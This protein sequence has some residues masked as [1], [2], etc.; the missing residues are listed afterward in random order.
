MKNRAGGI[1]ASMN[2]INSR[3]DSVI[4]APKEVTGKTLRCSR[5]G[6]GSIEWKTLENDRE[7]ERQSRKQADQDIG[8]DSK[9]NAISFPDNSSPQR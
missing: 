2:R 3:F 8:I 9:V 6:F 5:K 1:R 4:A 7:R